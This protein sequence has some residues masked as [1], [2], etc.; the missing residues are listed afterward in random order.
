MAFFPVIDPDIPSHPYCSTCIDKE[1]LKLAMKLW[2]D[3]EE[4]MSAAKKAIAIQ[5]KERERVKNGDAT[6]SV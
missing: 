4:M 3:D 5:R 1:K 6:E 2:G